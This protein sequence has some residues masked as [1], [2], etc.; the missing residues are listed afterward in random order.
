ML[1]FA[2]FLGI[3]GYVACFHALLPVVHEALELLVR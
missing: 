1:I 2:V 3:T